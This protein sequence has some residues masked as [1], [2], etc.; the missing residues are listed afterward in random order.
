[1]GLLGFGLGRVG[2]VLL[3]G[4][5]DRELSQFMPDH[6]LGHEH[7]DECPPVVDIERQPDEIGRDGGPTRPSLDRQ[8]R[9]CS[10]GLLDFVQQIQ[11]DKRTLF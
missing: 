7:R 9:L 11:V 8:L 2:A 10:L 6:V 1:M 4:P 3:E 5:G